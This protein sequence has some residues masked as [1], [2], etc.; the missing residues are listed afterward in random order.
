M[1]NS[2][3]FNPIFRQ[4]AISAILC[5]GMLG[6]FSPLAPTAFAQS[7]EVATAAPANASETV[8]VEIAK[9][10][11]AIQE[12]M[13]EKKYSE[14]LAKVREAEAV[15]NKTPYEI[16]IIDQMR[17]AAA[18]GVGDNALAVQSFEAVLATGRLK[19][20]ASL[21]IIE[22]I[23]GTYFRSKNYK[24]AVVWARRFMAEG[25]TN[26]QMRLLLA[27]SLYL[28]DEYAAAAKEISA[29]I[30]AAEAAGKTPTEDLLK[31]LASCAL[32]LKDNAA[33]VVALEKLVIYYP[34][35]DYWADYIYR[36]ESKPTFSDRL[37]L[38]LYRLKFQLDLVE[39]A[40][41]YMRM[42]QLAAQAGFPVETKQVLEQGFTRGV[43]GTGTDAA[44]QKKLKDSATK[45]VAEDAKNSAKAEAEALAA[46][47]G[48]AL[49][50]VGFDY[51]LSGQ[52]DKGIPLMEQ[53]IKK[54]GLKRPEEA[55]L[56]LGMAYVLAGQKQKALDTLKT[57]AGAD[58]TADVAMLWSIY[59]GQAK[60]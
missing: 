9:P 31:L 13:K 22:A 3:R 40:A 14:A 15:A 8:R 35:K 51:V 30:K 55:T 47:D 41:D 44:A 57:A 16:F 17:G 53:G 48:T 54:G 45:E 26:P 60:K 5:A 50:G 1:K 34:K 43:L 4:R 24:S 37:A 42:A 19:S 21:P 11:Q 36:F 49:V 25:G 2:L 27:Q 59:A 52:A 28:S 58:G 7:K 32:K 6:G 56:H 38:N 18:A 12:L 10:L 29:D 23:A 20:E 33:Y 46:K 39:D